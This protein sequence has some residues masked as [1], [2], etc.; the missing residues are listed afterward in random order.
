[1]TRLPSLL[2]SAALALACSEEEAAPHP[3]THLTDAGIDATTDSGS[4]SGT[5][6]GAPIRSVETRSP[7]GALDPQNLLLDGDFELS[8]PD[9]LQYPWFAFSDVRWQTGAACRSGLRCAALGG[10]GFMAGIFV[11]PPAGKVQASIWA[12]V[13]SGDCDGPIGAFVSTLGG[14]G[15][16]FG[17]IQL[18]PESPTPGADGWCHL[19]GTTDV[20]P[21][22]GREFWAMILSVSRSLQGEVLFDAASILPVAAALSPPAPA[23]DAA[24]RQVI[25]RARAAYAA[26]AKLP[27]RRDPR[28]V[29]NPTARLPRPVR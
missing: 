6:A 26:R 27:P 10:G 9:A 29:I 25:A 15:G 12:R 11:W 18:A 5:D 8:G 4:D 14:N 20:P 1:M 2:L 3:P 22:T 23:P 16:G 21:D 28:P 24:G 19:V 13:P 7:Y 17:E